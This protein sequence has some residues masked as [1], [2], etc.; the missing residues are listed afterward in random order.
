MA[1]DGTTKVIFAGRNEVYDLAADPK[2]TRD[3]GSNATLCRSARNALRDYPVPSPGAAPSSASLSEEDRRTRESRLRERGC[4]PRDP[5]GRAEA[6]GHGGAF[7]R[8]R[9]G[10]RPV[11]A[12]GVR[13]RHSLL[14]RILASDAFNLNVHLAT[15][16]S[17]LDTTPRP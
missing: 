9:E 17:A 13:P 1:V 16:H 8:D 6:G 2:E 3:I 12:R 4:R 7:R 15:A 10:L 11:R 5:Q 14:E